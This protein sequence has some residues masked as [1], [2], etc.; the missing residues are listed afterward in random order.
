[1]GLPAIMEIMRT[2]CL[3]AMAFCTASAQGRTFSAAER[4]G[5]I[6]SFRQDLAGVV[7]DLQ[8]AVQRPNP[9]PSVR[10]LTNAALGAA[11]LGRPADEAESL[12][13]LAFGLQDM[14]KGTVPWQMGHPEINDANAIEFAC[15][16][17]G[18]LLLHYGSALSEAFKQEMAP[19]IRAAFTAMRN[20]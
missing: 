12:M 10:D 2:F 20:H 6:T 5:H 9:T 1:P 11:A 19:H 15:Q 16:A 3:L 7:R 4:A 18:P 17:V 13:R 8:K 14:E